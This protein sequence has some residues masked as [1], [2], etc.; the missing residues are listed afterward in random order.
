[1]IMKKNNNQDGF[2]LIEVT[3]AIVILTIGILGAAAMQVA[4][5]DGNYTANRLTEAATWG[6]DQLETLMTLSYD[7][8]MLKDDNGDGVAGLTNTD[9]GANLADGGPVLQDNQNF[10]IFWNVADDYPIFG[11]KTIRVLIR[12]N[13]KG[14]Q[15][16]IM[17]DYIKMRP[18]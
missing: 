3:V 14:V 13:D 15:K 10:Q 6:G 18:I 5:I 12:R 1:M 7:D 17:Q 11:T 2:T 4:S 8:D 9:V 16:T